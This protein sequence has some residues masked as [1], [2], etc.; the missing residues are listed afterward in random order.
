MSAPQADAPLWRDETLLPWRSPP[1][2]RVAL[3]L[4][5]GASNDH[6]PLHLDPAAARAVGLPDVIAHGMLGMAQVARALEHWAGRGA[7]REIDTRFVAPI[8]VD[9]SLC[10]T[11]TSR[12]AEGDAVRLRTEAA[13]EDGTVMIVTEALLVR[14]GGEE[15]TT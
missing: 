13:G 12:S 9:T 10:V 1:L 3:A 15:T 7:V 2:G 11:V 8:P 14:P 4:Y 6:N 5:A